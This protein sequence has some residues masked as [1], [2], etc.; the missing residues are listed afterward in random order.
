MV[1]RLIVSFLL[2]IVWLPGGLYSTEQGSYWRIPAKS[3]E[4]V[5]KIAKSGAHLVDA[6]MTE[7]RDR[8]KPCYCPVDAGKRIYHGEGHSATTHS[9]SQ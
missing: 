5:I 8:G 7:V 1:R 9:N 2:L 6:R 4:D 3:D